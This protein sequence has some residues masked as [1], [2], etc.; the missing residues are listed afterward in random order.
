[1]PFFQVFAETAS[2]SSTTHPGLVSEFSH[3]IVRKRA[4]ASLEE[5]IEAAS[6]D[7]HYPNA[8]MYAVEATTPRQAS[9]IF[10]T[11]DRSTLRLIRRGGL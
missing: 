10:R 8:D 7:Q 3:V 1:V 9:A 5:V 6:N 11:A 4:F 2:V